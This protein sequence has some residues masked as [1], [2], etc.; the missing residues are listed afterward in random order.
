MSGF[1]VKF[2]RNTFIVLFSYLKSR[3]FFIKVRN[4]YFLNFSL[5]WLF[6]SLYS[7]L[8]STIYLST[9]STLIQPHS[10][11][12]CNNPFGFLN[13]PGMITGSTNVS[14]TLF[15]NVRTSFHQKVQSSISSWSCTVW[16]SFHL[17][18]ARSLLQCEIFFNEFL[19]ILN[20][21]F[22]LMLI[23]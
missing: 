17:P 18:S 5:T 16:S 21:F 8:P 19:L 4:T 6:S 14:A 13:Q 1:D 3:Q 9:Y 2:R 22:M 20:I 7:S 23:T 15:A 12:T 11:N 10:H